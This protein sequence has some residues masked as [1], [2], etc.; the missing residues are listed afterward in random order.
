MTLDK[1]DKRLRELEA[2]PRQA[3]PRPDE[4]ETRAALRQLASDAE[5]S[6]LYNTALAET[7]K[8]VC[9]HTRHGWCNPC[10]DAAPAVT[11]AWQ[12][13]AARMAELE[14]FHTHT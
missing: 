8:L 6:E 14:L 9:P 7:A 3:D 12:A 1:F 10:L 5:A 2:R 13:V 11:V 4:A